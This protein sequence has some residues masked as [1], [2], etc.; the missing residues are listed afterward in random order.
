MPFSKAREGGN[1]IFTLSCC[2]IHFEHTNIII[3]IVQK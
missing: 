2:K 1:A 3:V